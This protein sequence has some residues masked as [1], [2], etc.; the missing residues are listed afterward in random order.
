M[1][2]GLGERL[3]RF[4]V[5]SILHATLERDGLIPMK[6][7]EILVAS[8]L[9][10]EGYGGRDLYRI[11]RLPNGQWSLPLNLGP[12]INTPY[13]E[14]APFLHSDGTTLFFSSNGHNKDIHN[15]ILHAPIKEVRVMDNAHRRLMVHLINNDLV[16]VNVHREA[17]GHR[18]IC[19]NKDY[20]NQ[21]RN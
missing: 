9:F 18:R 7:P 2:G 19:N 15:N 14:D 21:D 3:A 1:D 6:L 16:M 10:E 12:N 20:L 13:D 17:K 5:H 4:H 8:A 11:R